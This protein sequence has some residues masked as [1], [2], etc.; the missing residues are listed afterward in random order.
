MLLYAR[1]RLASDH[2]EL[3]GWHW[4]GRYK[5]RIPLERVVHVDVKGDEGL[6]LWLVDGEVVRLEIEQS[7][8]WRDRLAERLAE[9]EG[10]ND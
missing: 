10:D 1:A 5:R 6:I 3:S 8:L 9:S 2:L 4:R 7:H